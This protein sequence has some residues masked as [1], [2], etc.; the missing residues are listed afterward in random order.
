M[1]SVNGDK[2]I[3]KLLL[4]SGEYLADYTATM[5]KMGQSWLISKNEYENERYKGD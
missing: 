2:A 3:V 5:Q 4:E 1:I